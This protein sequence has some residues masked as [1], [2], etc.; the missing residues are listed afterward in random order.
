MQRAP[1]LTWN[2]VKA[3]PSSTSSCSL[4]VKSGTACVLQTSDV[5]AA[6]TNASP[7]AM[8]R[9]IAVTSLGPAI[10]NNERQHWPTYTHWT[11]HS[12]SLTFGPNVS[13]AAIA[14]VPHIVDLDFFYCCLDL[15]LILYIFLF[16]WRV[17]ILA[18]IVAANVS[19]VLQYQQAGVLFIASL[20]IL[21]LLTRC[22]MP[23]VCKD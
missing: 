1:R 16:V 5:R 14:F 21:Y 11:G 15:N 23:V 17:V 6:M 3:S 4:L 8:R 9:S 13:T 7:V 19:H 22:M 20:D 2:C 12:Y 18:T 10:V